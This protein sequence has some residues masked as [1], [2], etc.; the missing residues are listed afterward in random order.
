MREAHHWISRGKKQQREKPH[1]IDTFN[2]KTWHKFGNRHIPFCFRYERT[3]CLHLPAFRFGFEKRP[4]FIRVV[5]LL[6][7][8]SN[9]KPLS[10]APKVWKL[11]I[12]LN[13]ERRSVRCRS[14]IFYLIRH[15]I[16]PH[17]PG[18]HMLPRTG[19]PTWTTIRSPR[20]QNPVV[21]IQVT[22]SIFFAST[23][24]QTKVAKRTW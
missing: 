8:P 6:K 5:L 3:R 23:T 9:S 19:S 24:P 22:S 4:P 13:S 17:L 12:L 20:I 18:G 7:Q 21:T 14:T 16:R 11:S 1:L 15:P 10:F 2:I